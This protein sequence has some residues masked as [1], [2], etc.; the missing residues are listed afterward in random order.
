VVLTTA[1]V[2]ATNTGTLTFRAATNGFGTNT[3]TVVMTDNGGTNNGGI[4]AYTNSFALGVYWIKYSPSVSGLTNLT[5]LENATNGLTMPFTITDLDTSNFTLTVSSSNTNVANVTV[6]NV[7]K[8]GTLTLVPQTNAYGSTTITL[9]VD[10]GYS[11]NNTC[12]VNFTLNVLMV[13]HAPSFSLSQTNITV[14][15]YQQPVTISS[16]ATNIVAGP[17]QETN[18]SVTLIVSNSSP[19]R[20]L[21]QPAITT[22]G[23]L[24]FTP[25][26]TGGNVIV[27]VWA[28]DNGGTTNGGIDTSAIQTFTIVIPPNPFNYLKG[29]FAGLFFDTN[30]LANESAGYFRLTLATNGSFTGYVLNT[31]AS[32][33]F[34]GQFDATNA[35]ATATIAPAHLVL[36]LALDIGDNWTE[37]IAGSVS[38]TVANWDVNL[39]ACLNVYSATFQT[40]FAAGYLLACPG[41]DDAQGPDGD[42]TLS[43]IVNVDGTTSLAGYL[44]DNTQIAQAG[45]ISRNGNYPLYAAVNATDVIFGWLTLTNG[46]TFNLTPDSEI[47]WVK[48]AGGTS[49]TTGFTNQS[50]MSGSIYDSTLRDLLSISSA[51]VILSGGGLAAPITNAVTIAANT[52]VVDPS[53]TNG[54]ALTI[55]RAS[56]EILGSFTA[57]GGQ[58]K[59]IYSVILQSTNSA[60]GYFWGNNQSGAFLMK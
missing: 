21:V 43:L 15:L 49:Y 8:S 24:T 22:N 20:F 56:G 50:V 36:T 19:T 7:N 29:Q 35:T 47:A 46:G 33:T 28:H 45:Q 54:L 53:A 52:I 26:A 30:T 57:P 55:N 48:K 41:G 34:S 5:I 3:Y 31:G 9:T 6:T 25:Q 11:T 60:Q 12:T 42:G 2:I 44:A 38:N 1:P 14:G 59:A 39:L 27:S 10:D 32:N 40:D 13:N 37:S 17:G 23:T 16:F 4:N 58:V 18:Q 51:Q